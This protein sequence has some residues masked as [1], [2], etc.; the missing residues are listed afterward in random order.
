MPRS[1]AAKEGRVCVRSVC[2][3][4]Q[5]DR[6]T[7]ADGAPIRLS[8]KTLLT[9]VFILTTLYGPSSWRLSVYTHYYCVGVIALKFHNASLSLFLLSYPVCEYSL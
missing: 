6:P 5:L 3:G 2:V 7:A 8:P 4:G 1:P 9:T